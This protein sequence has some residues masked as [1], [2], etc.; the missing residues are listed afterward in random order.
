MEGLVAVVVGLFVTVAVATRD[1]VAG[2]MT[3]G[4]SFGSASCWAPVLREGVD[5]CCL[6]HVLKPWVTAVLPLHVACMAFVV[7]LPPSETPSRST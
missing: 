4:L 3:G 2:T 7:L 1:G 5:N 6:A